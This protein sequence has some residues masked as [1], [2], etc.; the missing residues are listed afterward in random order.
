MKSDTRSMW[1]VTQ[2]QMCGA[3][4]HPDVWCVDTAALTKGVTVERKRQSQAQG[5]LQK[6]EIQC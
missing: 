5:G 6:S 3:W 1:A 4:T 2:I